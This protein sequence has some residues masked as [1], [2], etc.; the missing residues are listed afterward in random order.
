PFVLLLPFLDKDS[1]GLSQYDLRYRHN[2]IDAVA[3][4]NEP[5]TAQLNQTV[6]QQVIQLF[7]CPTNPLSSFRLAGKDSAGYGTTDYAPLPYVENAAWSGGPANSAGA[8]PLLAG[9][10]TGVMYPNN[11]YKLYTSANPVINQNK[12]IHLDNVTNFG[13][14]D[15][16]FGLAKIAEISEGTS[17]TIL[18][19][20]DVGRNEK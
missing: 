15:A 1:F 11:F 6:S 13:K 19:Y 20:E 7:L 12:L 17:T 10:M 16:D 5:V 4:N 2:Q 18:I 9:A 3:T 14:I 8:P